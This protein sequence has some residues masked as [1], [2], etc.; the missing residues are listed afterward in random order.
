MNFSLKLKAKRSSEDSVPKLK[1]IV[2]VECKDSVAIMEI[3][4]FVS[5]GIG[6][7]IKFEDEWITPA[8]F[9]RRA[10]SRAKKYSVSLKVNGVPLKHYIDNGELDCAGTWFFSIEST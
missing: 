7:C 2:D 8:E 4:K 10:G 5:G 3:S 9:E 6:E 1:P